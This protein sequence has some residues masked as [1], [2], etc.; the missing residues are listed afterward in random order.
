MSVLERGEGDEREELERED[1]SEW[2]ER[3]LQSYQY[4]RRCGLETLVEKKESFEMEVIGK[5]Y[6]NGDV[7]RNISE[8][9]EAFKKQFSGVGNTR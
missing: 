4:V 9:G 5:Q 3:V 8:R 7:K 6:T 1:P 2:I